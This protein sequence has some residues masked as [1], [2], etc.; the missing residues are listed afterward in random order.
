MATIRYPASITFFLFVCSKAYAVQC[1]GY[2]SSLYCHKQDLQVS[3]DSRYVT[4]GRD[5]LDNAGIQTTSINYEYGL[6][7]MQIWNGWGYES[8]YDELNLIPSLNYHYKNVDLY[9]SFNHKRFI[10]DNDYD[11]EIGSGISYSGLPYNISL[12]FDWYHSFT[13]EGSFYELSLGSEFN[14]AESVT[15]EPIMTFGINGGYITDGHDG[16]NHVNFKIDGKYEIADTVD[17]LGYIGYNIP[18]NHDPA[19]YPGDRLLKHF[20]W[21]G[22]GLEVRF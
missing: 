14:P 16:A 18:I 20:I 21:G 12:G 17:V 2:D 15:I 11:N 9:F 6:F 19:A 5:N 1:H 8:G 4:E 10:Q 22:I 3:W 13:Y 7:G